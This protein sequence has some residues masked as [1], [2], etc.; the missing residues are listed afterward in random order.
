M[1]L[2]CRLDLQLQ[3]KDYF[4][5]LGLNFG[6]LGWWC[7]VWEA[8]VGDLFPRFPILEKLRLRFKCEATLVLL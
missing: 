5:I 3:E 1:T 8:G 7:S 4:I 6:T 2:M